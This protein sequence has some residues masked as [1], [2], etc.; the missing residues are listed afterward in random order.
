MLQSEFLIA[1][2]NSGAGKTTLTLGIMKALYNRGVKV[3]PFKCG[4][5]YIDT[6]LHDIASSEESINLDTFFSS[7]EHVLSIYNRYSSRANVSVV[8]GAMGLFDGYSKMKGSAAEIAKLIDIPVILVINAK[9]SAYSTAAMIYGFKNFD[10]GVNIKGVIFNFVGSE[11]HYSFLKEACADVGVEALG[12]LPKDSSLEI[13]SRHL[14]LNTDN[15]AAMNIAIDKIASVVE[16]YVN[17]DLLLEITENTISRIDAENKDK[18]GNTQRIAVAKDEA[19]NFM[20]RENRRTLEQLGEIIWFSPIHDEVLPK[21]DFVYIPGGYPELY[22]EALS[23]NSLMK[24]SIKSYIEAGGRLLAEC[25]GMMYLSSSLIDQEGKSYPMVGIF[26][27]IATMDKMKLKLGYR[28][29]DYNGVRFKGHEFHYSKIE[30][31]LPSIVQQYGA[32]G[33]AVDTK[34]LRY[35]NVIAGYTHLYWADTEDWL[36]LFNT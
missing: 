23:K 11:S 20:Y 14:G 27:Q 22:A 4:P 8:E 19:F 29:F 2:A 33:Q 7:D 31:D 21:A 26:N 13:P 34:L 1:A 17:I 32:K 15:N 6:K 3:Q 30:S 35:K 28:Y 16:K 25:G 9:A 10:K 24:E 12:Y 5:D 18:T 36:N